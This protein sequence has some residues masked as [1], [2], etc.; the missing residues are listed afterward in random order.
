[1]FMCYEYTEN[2]KLKSNEPHYEWY[3]VKTESNLQMHQ[4]GKIV[5]NIRQITIFDAKHFNFWDVFQYHGIERDIG[6]T[7]QNHL[8]GAT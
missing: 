1:M 7:T 6:P 5:G 4:F 3:S 2:S 8:F